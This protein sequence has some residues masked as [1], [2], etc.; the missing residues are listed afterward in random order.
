MDKIKNIIEL[1]EKPKCILKGN[2]TENEWLMV[3]NRNPEYLED[4]PNEFKNQKFYFKFINGFKSRIEL[5]IN[6]IPK[7][8]IDEEII[9][10]LLINDVNF[11]LDATLLSLDLVKWI[12]ENRISSSYQSLFYYP[13]Y[14][15]M[16]NFDN[17]GEE[18]IFMHCNALIKDALEYINLNKRAPKEYLRVFSQFLQ[19]YFSNYENIKYKTDLLDN[20]IK[21]MVIYKE[22][23]SIYDRLT[24]PVHNE[25]C[26]KTDFIEVVKEILNKNSLEY[27]HYLMCFLK[28]DDIEEI[29]VKNLNK[30]ISWS[31]K[32][33]LQ[34]RF[35]TRRPKIE[36]CK[37]ILE[38]NPLFIE[39]FINNE[40]LILALFEKNIL[41][42]YFDVFFKKEKMGEKQFNLSYTLF[43]IIYLG[44]F[45]YYENSDLK[46]KYNKFID[47][48]KDFSVL[49]F[50]ISHWGGVGFDEFLS[51]NDIIKLFTSNKAYIYRYDLS[52]LFDKYP[53]LN[54][55]D[56][57]A[58][59]FFNGNGYIDELKEYI[60]YNQ[61]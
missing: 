26:K 17:L 52:K 54:N 59:R 28:N 55:E 15:H 48:Y 57:M 30:D 56:F 60:E 53:F 36:N 46:Q 33:T 29:I 1:I 44:G 21:L 16:E 22:D 10:T 20:I 45:Q 47:E 43:K 2:H 35:N 39:L 9:K 19:F 61:K 42:P 32:T 24:L 18:I 40:G 5:D 14:T 49:N 38:I 6:M 12:I 3:L 34:K 13:F 11:N 8:F 4:L 50:E 37:K 23:S 51:K 25:F 27:L 58:E 7:E 31:L 41:S